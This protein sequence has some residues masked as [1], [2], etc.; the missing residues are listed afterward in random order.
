MLPSGEDIP[1]ES[2]GTSK[3]KFGEHDLMVT[4]ISRRQVYRA[5]TRMNV[6]GLD[7]E[8]HVANYVETE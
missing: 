3:L 5:G 6:R 8:G 4:L 7:D 1:K 2:E